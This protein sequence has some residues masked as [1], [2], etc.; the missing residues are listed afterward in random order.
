MHDALTPHDRVRLTFA[1]RE[2]DRVP[3]LDLTRSEY[4][5][6][7]ARNAPRS[8]PGSSFCLLATDLTPRYPVQILAQDSDDI[9]KTTPYGSVMRVS[10]SGAAAPR[11]EDYALKTRRDWE[12]LA[13]RLQPGRDRVEWEALGAAYEA[14]R[15]NGL[16]VA[17]PSRA[18][19]EAC[20]AL[21]GRETLLDLLSVDPGLVC[22]VAETQAGLLTGTADLL[23]A[24][25]Y[26]LDAALLFDEMAGSKGPFLE[27]K[28]Y[29]DTLA[30]I[31][32]RLVDFFHAR[33][34]KVILYSGGDLRILL[35]ELLDAGLDC[36]GPLEV[37]AGMDLPV[38]MLNYGADLAFLG[39]IDRRALQDPDPAVL[40]GEIARKV[41]SG[42]V[43]G[44]YIAGLDGP[45][46][47]GISVEQYAR[48]AELLAKHGKY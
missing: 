38:L 35:P 47:P 16:Y 37:A 13:P 2:S 43:N 21:M 7:S 30:P 4:E 20:A 46:P 28:S 14:A 19:F 44:R 31:H 15:A 6:E 5:T 23:L 29:R 36:L 32:R 12:L 39:G 27:L 40:E 9:V 48:V 45:L 17:L 24:E 3:V 8:V 26:R 22:E 11:I 18:G 1:G 25:G 10:A 41:S 34:M 33:D 42:M